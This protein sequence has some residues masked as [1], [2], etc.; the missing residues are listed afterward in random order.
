MTEQLAQ[1]SLRAPG[2]HIGRLGRILRGA[3]IAACIPYVLLKTAWV[4]GGHI[5]I[6]EGSPLR[7]SGTAL[8]VAN[9]V[10]VFLDAGV[11]VL[12]LLL[13][14]PWGLRV[15]PWLLALPVWVATGLLAP[16]IIGFPVQIVVGLLGGTRSTSQGAREPFLDQWVF[17]VVYA[18]FIVQ[19]LSLG[20]LFVLYARDRW[21]ELWRGR[22]RDLPGGGPTRPAQRAAAAAAALLALF[23]F[24]MHLLWAFGATAGLTEARIEERTSEF[25]AL[26]AVY[27]LFAAATVVGVVMIAF[28]RGRSAPLQVPLAFAFT[29]SGALACWG[30][31]MLTSSVVDVDPAHETTQLMSASYSVQIIVGALVVTLA[32]YFFTERAAARTNSEM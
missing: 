17:G 10:G 22:V 4:F 28:R 15:P 31:W 18:G 8:P 12:A 6:P 23:P 30:A 5:G 16:I 19:G 32:A 3:A 9:A 29:G 26:E 14:R 27:A 24:V 7:E 2:F 1:P 25:Y 21:G 20:A 13:T 11:V